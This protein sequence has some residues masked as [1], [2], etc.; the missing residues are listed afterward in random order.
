MEMP[1]EVMPER[2]GH[3]TLKS[4]CG[5]A[6]LPRCEQ[7]TVPGVIS[8]RACA[9]YGARWMLAAVKDVIH[10]VH[11][12]VGCAYN[13]GTV[14][15]KSYSIA[16]T[17]LEERDIIFG[18][19]E[20]LR[21]TITEAVHLHPEAE[22]VLVYVTCAAGL[23]GEDVEAICR[24]ASSTLGRPVAPVLCPGFCGVGQGDGHDAAAEA[25]LEHFID[26]GE[27]GP[28][29]ENSVNILGEFDVQ[30]DLKEIEKL[31]A[32]LG[33]NIVCAVS[34]RA[35]VENMSRARRA[36]LNIVHC[37]RTGQ[38]MA[39]VME[40]RYGIPQMKVS[41]F[42]LE[43]TARAL[44]A[45]GRF[46]H[47]DGVERWVQDRVVAA[48]RQAA[49]YLHRLAGKRVAVFF[50]ASRMGSMAKAFREL[51]MELIMAGSQFGCREDYREAG[52][53]LDEGTLLLDDA[54]ERE[55]TEFL[56]RRRPH[57]LVG[58]T[59]EKFLAHK[60]GVPFLVFPQETSPYAGFNGFVNLAREVAVLLDAPVWRLVRP[61][62]ESGP[63]QPVLPENVK[64]A[65]ASRDGMYVDEHFGRAEKFLVF[66]LAGRKVKKIEVR[67][68]KG[69]AVNCRDGAARGFPGEKLDL[70]EDCRAVVCLAA[71]HCARE[72][73]A[74]KGLLI[75]ETSD[76]VPAALDDCI[77]MI[78]GE[79]RTDGSTN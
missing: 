47:R 24:E 1:I 71:G 33:L 40:K 18:G 20:K 28:V 15:R 8:Q 78:N 65:V 29:L 66:T 79:G 14:R 68:V 32:H 73:A 46:F 53:C 27:P 50:G 25:L 41:F 59:R 23:I 37:R 16:T 31:L 55:L 77:R 49:P 34:G 35:T 57:L 6:A 45:V 22:G 58:G 51:G 48:R 21:R 19:R 17:C 62:W 69:G 67:A 39:D 56:R 12:P 76:A 70:L 60:L 13:A 30:G 9:L 61:G 43:E 64:V 72:R 52:R 36:A 38:A 11:G 44:K 54:N 75:M 63:E 26:R 74:E 3:I 10:L 4:D 42:G 5:E 7:A 2:T